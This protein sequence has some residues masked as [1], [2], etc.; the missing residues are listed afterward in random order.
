MA[1]EGRYQRGEITGWIGEVPISSDVS[2]EPEAAKIKGYGSPVAGEADLLICPGLVSGNMMGKMM[3]FMGARS[4]NV[5]V[6]ARAPVIL[7]SR[8]A[9][10]EDKFQSIL[11]GA[12]AS[13]EL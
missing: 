7:C 5:V 11:L 2:I 3:L 12:I 4:A 1:L 13:Q 10:E 8:S 9:T 6:G